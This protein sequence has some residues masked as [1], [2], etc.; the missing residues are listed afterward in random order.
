MENLRRFKASCKGYR[1]N[2]TRTLSKITGITESTEPIT[3][4][5]IIQLKTWLHQLKQKKTMLEE[6]DA[7][8][9]AT[10]AQEGELADEICRAEEYKIGKGRL[11]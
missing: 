4:N 9:V 5:Q 10:I 8:I 1:T 6:F 7:K 11:A 2:I 3:P